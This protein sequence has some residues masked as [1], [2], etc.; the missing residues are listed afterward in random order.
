MSESRARGPSKPTVANSANSPNRTGQASA[1]SIRAW[2]SALALPMTAVVLLQAAFALSVA[3]HLGTLSP[4]RAL[5]TLALFIPES[6]SRR[7]INDYDD[8]RSGVDRPGNA[9]PGSALDLGLP[10]ERVRLVGLSCFAVSTAGFSYLL[11][12]TSPLSVLVIPLAF[13]TL[14]YSGGPSPIGHRALGEVMDFLL[15]G[16]FVVGVVIWVNVEQ[17]T[18]PVWLSAAAAGFLFVV[19]MF[20]NNLRDTGGDLAAGKR[21][22]AQRMSPRTAKTAYVLFL[23]A[24]YLCMALV[25]R[26]LDALAP[27]APLITLPY[28]IWIMVAVAR[29]RLGATMP[30]WLHMP[31]LLASF[32]ALFALAEWI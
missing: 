27:A 16:C 21:T 24:P 15:T 29:S 1:G 4:P 14:L 22:I 6:I 12:T 11:Y 28:A 19:I 25:A 10:M 31:R 26:E 8:Y 2:I 9:R 3:R 18:A 20:H 23:A 17:L 30:S 5:L 13:A 32:F 7:L